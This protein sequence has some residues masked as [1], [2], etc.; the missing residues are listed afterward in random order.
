MLRLYLKSTS[1]S[2]S[3]YKGLFQSSR[4]KINSISVKKFFKLFGRGSSLSNSFKR[5]LTDWS[6]ILFPEMSTKA[7][8]RMV[9]LRSNT[10]FTR[11]LFC[12]I[13]RGIFHLSQDG[14]DFHQIFPI[15]KQT[16]RFDLIADF[17]FTSSK[18]CS[19]FANHFHRIVGLLGKFP[20]FTNFLE[21]NL[22]KFKFA[23][24]ILQIYI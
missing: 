2:L 14:I 12:E 6:K 21:V 24:N 11:T 13:S 18:Q 8:C 9:P 5:S 19:I 10:S 1:S 16:H 3:F 15:L 23:E 17:W 4:F 22:S 20:T 7:Y